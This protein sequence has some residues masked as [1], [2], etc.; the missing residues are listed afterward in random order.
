M[1]AQSLA[2]AS[3]LGS[4]SRECGVYGALAGASAPSD[5]GA[6][7]S[8]LPAAPAWFARHDPASGAACLLFEDLAAASPPWLAGDQVAGASLDA[9]RATLR[10]AAALHA[11]YWRHPL[12]LQWSAPGAWLPRLDS[13][14]FLS[15]DSAEFAASWPRWRA[16]FPSAAAA[17]PYSVVLAFDADP[18]RFGRAARRLLA[19]LAREPC[20]LLHGD[21]RFDNVFLRRGAGDATHAR[22]IDMGGACRPA[23]CLPPG[24]P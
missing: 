14:R 10:S 3:R 8:A 22:F 24:L 2:L 19:G 16:R 13:E 1:R 4:F 11:A 5:A 9:A 15:F 23:S 21:L 17:L 18:A 6:A 12:L 20:T 7:G